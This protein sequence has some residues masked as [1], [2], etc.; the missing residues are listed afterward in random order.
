MSVAHAL[1][2]DNLVRSFLQ[3]DVAFSPSAIAPAWTPYTLQTTEADGACIHNCTPRE[4]VL[5]TPITCSGARG[6]ENFLARFCCLS[7]AMSSS[8]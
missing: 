1:W 7:L 5:E 2:F 8:F 4:P 3:C 6:A